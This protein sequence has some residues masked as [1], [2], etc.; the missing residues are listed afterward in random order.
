MFSKDREIA[1][2]SQP[3]EGKYRWL[4]RYKKIEKWMNKK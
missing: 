4:I 2:G 1:D 3:A